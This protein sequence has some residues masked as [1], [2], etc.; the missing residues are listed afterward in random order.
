MRVITPFLSVVTPAYNEADNLPDLYGRL[1]EVLGAAQ[2]QWEWIVVDDHSRD[3]TF[4]VLGTLAAN[5]P[6]IT[7]LRLARNSG[8]HLA[9]A[10]GLREAAGDAAAIVAAD[11]QDP[12]EVLPKLLQEWRSGAQVV[13]GVRGRRDGTGAADGAFARLYYFIMRRFVGLS[14]MPSRGADVFL[15]DKLVVEALRRFDER[16]TSLLALIT[17]M[18]FRQTHVVYDKQPRSRG[19]SGWSLA[20]KI[21]LVLDSITAFSGFPLR[22]ITYTG[23]LLLAIGLVGGLGMTLTY[24]RTGRFDGWAFVLAAVGIGSGLQMV[25]V[26]VL[27][28]YVWR[29][30]DETRRRPA[31]LIEARTAPPE[32]LAKSPGV[33]GR[34]TP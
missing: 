24:L 17:W 28:E 3:A 10:C 27:G 14:A 19:S 21:K 7:G 8:S 30:L 13:W 6:R 11:L 2:V 20:K 18:G 22:W 15:I 5:D 23:G 32:P 29:T 33:A 1:R 26:G 9:I 4:D 12:P 16:H 31:Y 34:Y 25:A